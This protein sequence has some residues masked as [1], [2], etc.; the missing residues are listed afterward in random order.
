ML[1]TNSLQRHPNDKAMLIAFLI[2]T[3][4]IIVC[5]MVI[6]IV[7]VYRIYQSYKSSQ[8]QVFEI[9]YYSRHE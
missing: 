6:G 3:L 8:L 5:L 4:I 7:W 9:L 1:A 2:T